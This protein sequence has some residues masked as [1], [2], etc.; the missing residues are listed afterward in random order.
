VTTVAIVHDYVTQRGGAERVALALA[1]AF[2][3][4]PVHTSLY[5][6]DGTFPEFARLDVRPLPINRIAPLRHHHRIALPALAPSFSALTVRADVVVCSSSG[7]AHGASV[8]GRKVVYC[9]T[10]ARWL[11]QS[12][13]YL[14]GF[15]GPAGIA[16]R[17]LR[18]A[19]RSWD[20]RAAATADRYLVNST[21][22]QRRVADIYGI[23][24]EVVPAPVLVDP[25]GPANAVEG[26]EPGFFLCVSRLLSYKNVGAV[27]A[28]FAR[29]PDLQLL[30][31]GT[32]PMQDELSALAT[33]N[34]RLLGQVG[35]SELRW[36]Y[37]HARGL[38]AASY[39]DFGLT[40]VEAAAYGTPA[41]ALRW[42]GFLDTIVEG[43]TGVFFD[44][45]DPGVI[46]A[47]ARALADQSWSS[48][49]LTAHA[50]AFS[51]ARFTARLQAVVAQ[52]AAVQ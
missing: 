16:L 34:V 32:G 43:R 8:M 3:G 38:L 12:D 36:L 21:V 18:P 6:P 4:A 7:W 9:H 25:A 13:R 14:A 15:G 33:P 22:V 27:V 47:A 37:R 26:I 11:Y 1:Q 30:V 19:L 51:L 31:V 45:P 2:P 42:G 44:Q 17:A 10:P 28:A 29:L 41:A 24:A 39:E 40:P 20:R 50:E 52:E 23:E 35:D 49:V 46:A 5:D 48:D